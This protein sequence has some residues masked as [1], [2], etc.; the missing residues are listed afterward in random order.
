M[1]MASGKEGERRNGGKEEE[2]KN[3]HKADCSLLIAMLRGLGC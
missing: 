1:K 2:E 3:F